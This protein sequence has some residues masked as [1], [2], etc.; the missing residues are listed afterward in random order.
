MTLNSG[1]SASLHEPVHTVHPRH[2][3]DVQMDVR[4]YGNTGSSLTAK[5]NPQ[6]SLG[7]TIALFLKDFK[8]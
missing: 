1:D 4:G 7:V 2:Y 3:R 5:T 6:T 8:I